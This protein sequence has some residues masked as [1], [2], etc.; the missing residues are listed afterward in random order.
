MAVQCRDFI[1]HL[2]INGQT[3]G[4]ID[5]QHVDKF[6]LRLPQRCIDDG[7]RGLA[8]V[9]PEKLDIYF[10]RQRLKLLNRSRPVDICADQHDPFLRFGLEQPG[11]FGCRSG[12]TGALQT[13]HQH[14]RRRHR[15]QIQLRVGRAH[16]RLHFGLDQFDESLPGRQTF[17]HLLPDGPRTD[18]INEVLDHRQRDISFKQRTTNLSQ[19]FLDIAF[20][21]GRFARQLTKSPTETLS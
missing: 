17:R 18:P 5:Q 1:H 19:G 3:S 13:R 4:G 8:G 10:T 20:R 14:H 7:K 9:G 6:F 16:D 2:L 11:E 12:L 15:L 21:Q